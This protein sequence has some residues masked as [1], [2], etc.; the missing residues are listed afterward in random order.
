MVQRNPRY[1]V[2]F[3][4]YSLLNKDAVAYGKTDVVLMDYKSVEMMLRVVN[5]KNSIKWCNDILSLARRGFM[6][7]VLHEHNEEGDEVHKV[8][9]IERN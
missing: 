5:P 8:L 7:I 2:S 6:N 9:K 3:G 1:K 4:H